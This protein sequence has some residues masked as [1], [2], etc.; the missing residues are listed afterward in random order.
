MTAR[1]FKR[2]VRVTT[3]RESVPV[4]PTKFQV[5]RSTNTLEITD[6]RVQFKI[7]RTLTKHPNACDVTI[8][9][10]STETRTDL[11]TKPLLVQLDAGYEDDALRLMY[12]GDLRFGM[13]K[14]SGPNWETL[15]QLGDG[16]CM[17]RW[18]R[19]NKSYSPGTS[20]RTVLRDCAR[21][22]GFELPDNLASDKSLDQAFGTGTTAH[23]PSRDEFTRLLAPFG[24]HHSYQNGVLR[25]LR[26]DEA[27]PGGPILIGEDF[28]MIGTPEFGSP[29]RSGKP[30]HITV[31]MLLYPE[32]SPGCTVDLRSKVKNGLFRVESVRHE[33]DT[34]GQAWHTTLEIKPQAVESA[35][36]TA[37]NQATPQPGVVGGLLGGALGGV[38]SG[39][40]GRPL[41]VVD[42]DKFDALSDTFAAGPLAPK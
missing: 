17:H 10:L 24:Y 1:F 37:V 30:P 2:I 25:I 23:G 38:A 35:D 26:D 6:L 28:G 32:I 3:F 14:E 42:L 7:N 18:A 20:V 16:D 29:P 8:T 12:T 9:N 34:H 31:K 39:R 22:M 40:A 33:G 41:K 21:S 4:N 5:S 11:E 13:T 19:V 27:T 15:L 36:K